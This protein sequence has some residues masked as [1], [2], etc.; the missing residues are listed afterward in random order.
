MVCAQQVFLPGDQTEQPPSLE[1]DL[2]RLVASPS[3][4]TEATPKCW[5]QIVHSLI[6]P[7]RFAQEQG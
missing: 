6:L 2:L 3:I 4:Y 7:S 5:V 1:V